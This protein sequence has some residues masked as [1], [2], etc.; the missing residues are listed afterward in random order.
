[1]ELIGI[2]VRHP[3]YG[4][5]IIIEHKANYITIEFTSRTS[6]FIYPAAFEEFI[7]AEDSGIQTAIIKSI[8]NAKLVKQ[9]Q[10]SVESAIRTTS[11]KH[12]NAK[13]TPPSTKAVHQSS[14]AQKSAVCS[15]RI[16]GK[17]MTFY[18]FQGST[19]DREYRGGY[20]WA[21]IATKSGTTPHHWA[22]LLD[23]RKGDIILHG[24]DGYVQAISIAKDKC[25][26]CMQPDELAVEGLWDRTGRKVDCDYTYIDRP[27]KT[28]LFTDDIIR[29]CKAKY[30]PFDRDGNG[31]MGYLFEI[32]RELAKIF[33]RESI[34]NNPYLSSVNY[35]CELL[36]EDSNT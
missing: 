16:E 10:H 4:V 5:G 29:L 36:A 8:E 28:S 27:I 18:V 25:S 26:D 12:S 21:P 32:N 15:Q 11:G 19:F 23:V 35:I 24:C 31:N 9:Q 2:K 33:I 1:M 3:V 30:S 13:E 20:I 17:R 14:Q 6:K 22:R 34:K 7:T